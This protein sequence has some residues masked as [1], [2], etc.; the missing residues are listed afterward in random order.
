MDA[1]TSFVLITIGDL[2]HP[3][4]IHGYC[5]PCSNDVVDVKKQYGSNYLISN[6]MDTFTS[7]VEVIM[8]LRQRMKKLPI[9]EQY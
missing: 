6:L 7:F 4:R 9:S 1:F 8:T 3:I 5:L 2:F